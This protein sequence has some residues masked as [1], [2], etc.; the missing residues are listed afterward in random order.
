MNHTIIPNWTEYDRLCDWFAGFIDGEGTFVI[1]KANINFGNGVTY[2]PIFRLHLRADDSEI[3]KFL[4]DV[5]HIGYINYHSDRSDS[6][7]NRKPLVALS[8]QSESHCLKLIEILDSHPLRAKKK[9]DYEIWKNA[10]LYRSQHKV[11]GQTKHTQEYCNQMENYKQQLHDVRIYKETF[12]KRNNIPDS[13]N[14]NV[15]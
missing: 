5:F 9:K 1:S 11:Y 7:R 2:T 6:V 12:I 13:I 14:I 10:V 4:T 15:F 8:I 3:L